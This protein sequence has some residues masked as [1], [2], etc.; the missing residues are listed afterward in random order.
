MVLDGDVWGCIEVYGCVWWC[1]VEL[2]Y[3]NEIYK[4]CL[5]K[6]IFRYMVIII[7]KVPTDFFSFSFLIFLYRNF[8]FCTEI[9]I[10]VLRYTLLYCCHIFLSI[11][12]LIFCT[13]TFIFVLRFI[14]LYWD[15]YCCTVVYMNFTVLKNLVAQPMNMFVLELMF[16]Y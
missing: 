4:V 13:A 14:F 11:F 12:F 6:H 8:Y 10:S 2:I 15:K 16:L 9:Y 3:N 7:Y 5:N 1:I